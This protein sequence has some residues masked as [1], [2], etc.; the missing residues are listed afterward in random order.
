MNEMAMA[1]RAVLANEPELTWQGYKRPGSSEFKEARDATVSGEHVA[2][3]ERA[4]AWL[5]CMPKRATANRDNGNSYSLKH[6]AEQWAGE[7]IANGCL[8]AAALH[9]GFPVEP[10]AGTPNALIGVAGPS[11]WP[12]GQRAITN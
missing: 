6:A 8:I 9:L 12:K 2:Q 5:S 10:I 11:K 7:Y 3:F 4:V 1:L